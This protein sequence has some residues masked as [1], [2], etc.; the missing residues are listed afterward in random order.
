MP[1]TKWDPLSCGPIREL[2]AMQDRMNRLF[3]DALARTKVIKEGL[4]AAKHRGQVLGSLLSDYD[5][6]QVQIEFLIGRTIAVGGI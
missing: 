4:E 2:S 5:P 3:E 6:E 1:I